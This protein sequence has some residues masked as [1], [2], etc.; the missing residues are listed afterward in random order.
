[1]S[2]RNIKYLISAL[3]VSLTLTGCNKVETKPGN[4]DD[5][6]ADELT[7]EINNTLASLYDEY[8]KSDASETKLVDD[9]LYTI[10]KVEFGA[11]EEL[12]SSD[13]IKTKID[14]RSQEKLF[15]KIKS[16]VYQVSFG[17]DKGAFDEYK[18][19]RKGVYNLGYYL[20]DSEGKALKTDE[21][22]DLEFYQESHILP[23]INEENFA[24]PANEII[25]IDYYTDYLKEAFHEEIYRELLVE[26]Y[27]LSEQEATLGRNYA[28]KVNYVA[29]AE[30]ERYPDAVRRLFNTFIDENIFGPNE[31]DLEILA[32]AWRGIK[33]Q[34]TANEMELLEK[35]NLI[36]K[37]DDEATP[38]V[39]EG[40]Y[41]TLY[42][43]V[44]SDFN[45]I[46]D[47]IKTTDKEIENEFTNNGT[48]SSELG[49]KNKIDEV[50]KKDL[51]TD[52]WAIKNGG[53]SSLP[54]AIRSRIFNI[55]TSNGVDLVKDDQGVL[56]DAGKMDEAFSTTANTF[57]RNIHGIYYL[58]PKEYEKN[59]NSNFLFYENGTYFI[60]QIEEAVNT[61]KLTEGNAREYTKLGK[62]EE[63]VT[64]IKDEIV[65]KLGALDTN[66]TATIEYFIK[67]ANLQFHDE[68]IKEFFE[69]KYPEIF[70]KKK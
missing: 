58:V 53:L 18:F 68:K 46:T 19:A 15:E 20:V 37:P 32:N 31:P 45:K 21:I 42:G 13:P 69:T 25:H 49:F 43:A 27:L 51:T 63:E 61:S 47:D 17:S 55:G 30:S 34:F 50:A 24:D 7:H 70:G 6:L 26:N 41:E 64:E 14:E 40:E 44:L 5:P 62:T 60:F 35:A 1:M 54:E 29:I 48:Q 2:K 22:D 39:D 4:Y 59:D 36:I 23:R 3:A 38:D 67:N 10:A 11:Y 33:E 57:V 56:A 9:L 66:R 8:M 52:G 28:R 65:R 12:E 16:S